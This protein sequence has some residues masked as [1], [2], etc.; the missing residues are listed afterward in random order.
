MTPKWLSVAHHF[1]SDTVRS[2]RLAASER[3]PLM[4]WAPATLLHYTKLK[5]DSGVVYCDE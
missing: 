1:D 2:R 3:S 4:S 5:H